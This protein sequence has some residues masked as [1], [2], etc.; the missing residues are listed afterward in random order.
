MT[1]GLVAQAVHNG[2]GSGND[3]IGTD[4]S[5]GGAVMAANTIRLEG[6]RLPDAAKALLE[7]GE[8]TD[9]RIP[10]VTRL[11]GRACLKR[12]VATGH[13]RYIN[14]MPANPTEGLGCN[15]CFLSCIP[16]S[17]WLPDADYTVARVALLKA[18]K[19]RSAVG[20]REARP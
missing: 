16:C 13:P 14:R 19:V 7:H 18:H 3:R 2:K 1:N 6:C 11:S 9:C 8:I 10:G 12:Q 4:S 5:Q 15:P 20:R 17:H